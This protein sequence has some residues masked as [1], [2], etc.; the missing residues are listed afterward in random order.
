MAAYTAFH[1]GHSANAGL[2]CVIST[3]VAT[4]GQTRGL[5]SAFRKVLATHTSRPESHACH[6]LVDGA[7]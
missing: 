6:R 3:H 7:R 1:P 5:V 4:L 2:E